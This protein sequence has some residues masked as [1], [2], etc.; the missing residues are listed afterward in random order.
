M[1][2]VA[3]D[4]AE[5][6]AYARQRTTNSDKPDLPRMTWV[7]HATVLVQAGGLNVLTDPMFS[8]RAFP[9]QFAGPRRAQ[10]PGVAL[11]DLPPI[12]V[13]L[14]SH[15]HLDHLDRTS[16]IQLQALAKQRSDKLLFL[17]PLGVKPLL[18]QWGLESVQELDWWDSVTVG[19]P[20]FTSLPHSI[21]PH[22]D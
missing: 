14:V 1:P 5:M 13:V 4:L 11:N 17:V 20:S 10:A 15:I 18:L 9:V 7:G 19:A 3:P 21:G 22:A 6:H 16:V 8:E 2:V 12:D